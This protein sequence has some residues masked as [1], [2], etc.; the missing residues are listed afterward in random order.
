[1]K[2]D[3]YKFMGSKGIYS[4]MSAFLF[5]VIMVFAVMFF[6]FLGATSVAI[7]GEASKD[8][9]P[10]QQSNAVKASILRCFSGLDET[11]IEDKGDECFE[12]NEKAIEGF[13]ISMEETEICEAK[14][15]E[16]GDNTKCGKKFPY[17]VAIKN[18]AGYNCLGQLTLCFE[19][20]K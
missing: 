9:Q 17:Y 13:Q 5:V 4:M 2:K 20:V 12:K 8:I 7:I 11:R 16:F 18:E 10:L 15:W 19:E 6:V 3:Q 1:M 14:E